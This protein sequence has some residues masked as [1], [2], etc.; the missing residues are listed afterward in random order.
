MIDANKIINDLL[1]QL[2]ERLNRVVEVVEGDLATVRTGRARPDLISGLSVL[3]YGQRMKLFEL[4]TVSAPDTGLLVISPW[5]KSVIA[6]IEKAIMASDLQLSPNVSGDVIKIAIPS[7]TEERRL[8]FVKLVHQKIE[9]GK[10]MIRQVRQEIKEKIDDLKGSSGISEDD[11]DRMLEQ[12]QRK[13]DEFG[14]KV[15]VLGKDKEAEIMAV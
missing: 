13:I 2:E 4:A 10:V 3:A 15:E 9:S 11:T 7:L 6:D 5:D 8:D 1:D 14:S 12:L